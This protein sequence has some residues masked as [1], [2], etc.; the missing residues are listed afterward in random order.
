MGHC[1]ATAAHERVK[2]LSEAAGLFSFLAKQKLA[3][4]C[5]SVGRAP[6]WVGHSVYLY[7]GCDKSRPGDEGNHRGARSPSETP[8]GKKIRGSRGFEYLGHTATNCAPKRRRK[9]MLCCSK[10]NN[11]QAARMEMK[12]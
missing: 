1:C 3:S 5:R 6:R 4:R 9:H 10:N 8:K 7:E 12:I 2:I 11:D